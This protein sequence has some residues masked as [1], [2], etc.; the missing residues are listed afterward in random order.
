MQLFK[1]QLLHSVQVVLSDPQTISRVARNSGEKF[2]PREL[3]VVLSNESF[4]QH[5][6]CHVE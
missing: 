4:R 2:Y 5:G 6:T 3:H 1:M